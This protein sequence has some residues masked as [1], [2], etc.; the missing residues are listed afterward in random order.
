MSAPRK[1]ALCFV[2]AALGSVSCDSAPQE[3]INPFTDLDPLMFDGTPQAVLSEISPL[4]K[5]QTG[6]VLRIEVTFAVAAIACFASAWAIG[7]VGTLDRFLRRG[8]VEKL[9]LAAL[10]I[11]VPLATVELALRPFTWFRGKSTSLFVRDETLGWKMRP[12]T[13]QPW[14]GVTV[15]TNVG[16]THGAIWWNCMH[17]SAISSSP[18]A[19]ARCGNGMSTNAFISA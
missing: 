16:C 6:D 1:L 12:S 9:V 5:H 10:T 8:L 4:G 15:S 7:R 17:R 18:K 11:L 13:V 19:M 14:G 2:A 3:Q